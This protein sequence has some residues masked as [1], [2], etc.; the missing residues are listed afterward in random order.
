MQEDENHPKGKTAE[1]ELRPTEGRPAVIGS[2]RREFIVQIGGGVA[3]IVALKLLQ[4]ELVA[5]ATRGPAFAGPGTMMKVS[6]K[7]NGKPCELQADTRTTLLDAL[8]EH[9]HLTGSKRAAT[10][11][12]VG[13][14][15]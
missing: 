6:F 13:R 12:N 2:T 9:L 15:R 11:A 10:R 4:E 14:A 8:R 7:V 5:Q 1:G 3:G